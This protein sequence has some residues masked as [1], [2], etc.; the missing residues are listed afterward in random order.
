MFRYKTLMAVLGAGLVL[1]AAASAQNLY[2]ITGINGYGAL[3]HSNGDKVAN[4]RFNTLHTVWEDG[5]LIK[6][7]TSADGMGWTAP[8]LVAPG[9]PSALPAIASDSNGTLAVAFVGNPNGSGMGAIHYAYKPWGATS[10][11]VSKIVN[12]GTQPDIEA[13]GGNVYVT[14]TTINRVQYTT[15]PTTSPPAA[16]NFGEEIEVTACAGTGFV[17]PSVALARESCKLVP[18]VAYIRYSDETSNPDPVCTSLI[19]EVGSRVCER[20]PVAGT[21]GL[22][23]TDLV[24]A[25]N[26]AQGVEAVALSMN[27][28]YTSGNVFVA[29]SDISNGTSRTRLA[30]GRNGTWNAITHSNDDLHV[31]VAAKQSSAIGEYR[32]AWVSRGWYPGWPFVDTDGQFRTGKWSSGATPTWTD[33]SSTYI[34]ASIGGILVGHPQATFWGKCSSG[35]Y[36]TVEAVAELENVCATSGLSAHVTEN[37]SC[38]SGGVIG[39][40]PCHEVHVAYAYADRLHTHVDVDGLGDPVEIGSNWATYSLE[41][42]K[43]EGY[44]VVAWDRGRVDTTWSGGFSIDDPTANVSIQSNSVETQLVRLES[45]D[46]Y[47]GTK[48]GVCTEK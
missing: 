22:E 7:S 15:F 34:N 10:W 2:Y 4:G 44:V 35:L 13:R 45:T 32:L 21:W 39:I 28:Q 24:T 12:S 47:E 33:P 38:P 36:D 11:T 40:N 46:I 31:H 5:A 43:G 17:R 37:Q 41:G 23:Y 20:D 48:P 8:Q 18:K 25:T 27:A 1:A 19:T 30:H 42:P 14:W 3:D 26:P 9:L 6:Y 16:M 29:W